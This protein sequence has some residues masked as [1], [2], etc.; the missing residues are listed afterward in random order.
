MSQRFIVTAQ[1][2]V[3]ADVAALVG[4]EATGGVVTFTGAVRRHSR[5]KEVVRLEYEAYVPMAVK[6]LVEIGALASTQAG[7]AEVAIWHRIG[8]L[9]I[10]EIAVV[11]AAAA[12]HRGPAFEA[13]R[14][15]I[16]E[17]KRSVPIWK[18]EIFTD[19]EEWVGLGP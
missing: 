1:P 15:A 17:L 9:A 4:S 5:G 3:L 2:I 6:K 7:G 19:G 14:F 8:T 18:K 10:G 16:E 12:A 11:I 13:C